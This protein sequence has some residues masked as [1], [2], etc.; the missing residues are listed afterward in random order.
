MGST[1]DPLSLN[2][3]AYCANAP[4]R[5]IDPSGHSAIESGITGVDF[6]PNEGADWMRTGSGKS[7]EEF[8]GCGPY[9]APLPEKF[10]GVNFGPNEGADWM[11][12][13]T[14]KSFFNC[15]IYDSTD[16]DSDLDPVPDDPVPDEPT[17]HDIEMLYGIS[18]NKNGQMMMNP[19]TNGGMVPGHDDSYIFFDPLLF[20]ESKEDIKKVVD[21]VYSLKKDL[22]KLYNKKVT[23]IPIINYV[24]FKDEWN[25]NLG[26][27]FSECVILLFHGEPN[28]IGFSRNYNDKDKKTDF[29]VED[30]K[31]LKPAR[32]KTLLFLSCNAATNRIDRYGGQL[33][34][35]NGDPKKNIAETFMAHN[36]IERV[37]AANGYVNHYDY[38]GDY[39]IG[40]SAK[41]DGEGYREVEDALGF[42]VYT[43]KNGKTI[44]KAVGDIDLTYK[45]IDLIW[46]VNKLK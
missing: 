5:Y 22:E 8:W 2:L 15:W 37:I 19:G 12:T 7:F 43:E 36:K 41:H 4:T 16:S 25:K 17:I 42:V 39:S 3:Y 13:G 35:T 30:I 27:K 10:T 6:G 40:S 32:I 9:G 26:N 18:I 23:L 45:L 38:T 44:K 1:G 29:N 21:Y 24:Q 34:E 46:A 31:D 20:G 14:G 28:M 33:Y 11:R